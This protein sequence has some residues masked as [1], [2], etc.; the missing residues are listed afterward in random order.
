MHFHPQ[1]T[2]MK[3]NR[4]CHRGD[5]WSNKPRPGCQDQSRL[6]LIHIANPGK[7]RCQQI[8]DTMVRDLCVIIVSGYSSKGFAHGDS[9]IFTPIIIADFAL[10]RQAQKYH[11]YNDFELRKAAFQGFFKSGKRG[12]YFASR[13]TDL[14]D[15]DIVFQTL[16]QLLQ[17]LFANSGSSQGHFLEFL[18]FG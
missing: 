13:K 15:P 11:L 7:G 8:A 6:V 16:S 4:L 18:V 9:V 12:F 17:T 10:L 5:L 3:L 1:N 14:A 2:L